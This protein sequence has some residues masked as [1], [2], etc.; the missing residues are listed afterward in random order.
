MTPE[1]TIRV[2]PSPDGLAVAAA[3]LFSETAR[4]AA[5][6]RGD[7]RVCL[8]GGS[9]P[10]GLYRRLAGDLGRDVPWPSVCAYFGDERCVPPDH[11]D[12]NYGMARATLLDRVPVRPECIF[13]IPGELG[14]GTAADTYEQTL[15]ETLVAADG[16]FDLV[17]LGLGTDGHTASLFSQTPALHV[18]DRWCT[19]AVA[20]TAPKERVTLTLP[21]LNAGRRVVFLVTGKEKAG[22][23]RA[24]LCGPRDPDRFPAQ[25]IQPTDGSLFWLLD[26][27]AASDLPQSLGVRRS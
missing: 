25:A 8:A 11:P 6:A 24:V 18:T 13:R 9:T 23:V 12:S 5:S 16:R 10:K 14:L 27:S 21:I 22:V 19:G 1:R 20:P 15:R 3:A 2:F 7:S 17:L 26:E 4:A